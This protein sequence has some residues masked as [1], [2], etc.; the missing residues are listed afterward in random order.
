[1]TSDLRAS[2]SRGEAAWIVVLFGFFVAIVVWFLQV[3]FYNRHFFDDGPLV[4]ADNIARIA[5]ILLLGWLVYAPGAAIAK[6]MLARAPQTVVSP[7]EQAAVGFGIGVGLWHVLMLILGLA[8]LYY[9]SV[10]IGLAGLILLCT[11]REFATVASASQDC[12]VR[13]LR[14]LKQGK[15]VGRFL[16]VLFVVGCAFALLLTR[17]LYPGGG[18]DYFTHYFYYY[19]DVLRR[20]DLSPNDVW[21]HYYYSKGYGLFFFAMLLTDP[22]APSLATYCCV[23]F[24]TAAIAGLVLRLA[25]GPWWAASISAVYLLWNL[26]A[27]RF[28]RGSGGGHFQKDH[29]QVTALIALVVVGLCMA[30]LSPAKRVWLVMA[31]SSAV[32]VTIIAQ[33][34]GVIVGGLFGAIGALYILR[35]RWSEARAYV[36]AGAVI[37]MTVA[38]IL[39]IGYLATGLLHDQ[40]LDLALQFADT[41]RL[42]R[43][44]VLPQLVIVSW[45]RDNYLDEVA[46]WSFMISSI[47]PGFM[48]LEQLWVFVLGAFLLGIA[49]KLWR[50]W[51]RARRGLQDI[52]AA[53]ERGKTNAAA[54]LP[55]LAFVLIYFAAV[56][57][58]LGRTQWVSYE[59]AST[60]F[61]P[62]L[63]LLSVAFYS[64][65]AALE[66]IRNHVFAGAAVPA[67]LL[68]ATVALWNVQDQWVER[69][70]GA[71]RDGA[72]FL[73]GT[74]SLANAYERQDGGLPFGGINPEAL[75]AYRA[76]EPGASIWATNVD[77]YCMAPGCWVGSVVSFKMSGKLDQILSAPPEKAKQLLQDEG[78]NYFLI[79]KDSL[80]LDLLPY[81]K[82]FSPDTIGRYLGIRW[83]DGSAFLL[84]WI[85]RNTVP[86]SQQFYDY[87]DALLSK[88]EHP[89]FR[90]KRLV[91]QYLEPATAALRAKKWGDPVE[92]AWRAPPPEGIL[93]VRDATYGLN[94][95]NFKPARVDNWVAPGNSTDYLRNACNNKSECEIPWAYDTI[96]DPASGCPKELTI[97]YRCGPL[98]FQTITV[99]PEAAGKLVSLRCQPRQE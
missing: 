9:R 93:L 55:I 98:P 16:A 51:R 74:Y 42:D 11:A 32:A 41:E 49:A 87:Y 96:G 68:L 66:R 28:A 38:A 2:R 88:K 37:G 5:F 22:E 83:T 47:L 46:S 95:K 80:L 10:M 89:W 92:F 26:V 20:H 12:L 33:P 14:L 85:G 73:S 31:T 3:D 36:V 90:F 91:D 25:P 6:T 79:S 60:F 57:V 54:V 23:A 39:L 50:V 64:W 63:L 84:T 24:A 1:M 18:G 58:V 30:W 21:Y 97:T 4:F 40:L 53:T 76:V 35:R 62:I 44:G 43:W 99:P 78:I 19:L 59:R 56:S 70:A 17:G 13:N 82:L 27:T 71:L 72:R 52:A 61:L 34:K 77:S 75:A 65:C 48:R 8:G 94:C 81:S 7:L 86:L 45:I 67:A 15:G 29:E 69:A